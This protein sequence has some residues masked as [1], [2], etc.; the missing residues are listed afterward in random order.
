MG[1]KNPIKMESVR[2]K[3]LTRLN[4]N[5]QTSS[6]SLHISQLPDNL[7]IALSFFTGNPD[8]PLLLSVLPSI[9][10]MLG[11]MPGLTD[12][13]ASPPAKW[14]TSAYPVF[15]IMFKTDKFIGRLE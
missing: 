9:L 12:Q 15:I 2:S 10:F 13:P 11:L 7:Q 1:E 3:N 5:A 14:R 8:K 4:M 6:L